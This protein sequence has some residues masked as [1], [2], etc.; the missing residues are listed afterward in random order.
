MPSITLCSVLYYDTCRQQSGGAAFEYSTVNELI[1]VDEG[2]VVK[3]AACKP[4]KGERAGVS[5]R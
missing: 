3:G 5:R 2:L 4:A 1:T